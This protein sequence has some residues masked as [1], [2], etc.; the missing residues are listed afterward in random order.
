M[1]DFSW[2][3][4]SP[5]PWEFFIPST[6]PSVDIGSKIQEINWALMAKKHK[7]Q[8]IKR[9]QEQKTAVFSQIT[10]MVIF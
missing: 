10:L 5:R 7:P 3:N 6:H 1:G 4:L 8:L 2:D 9:K